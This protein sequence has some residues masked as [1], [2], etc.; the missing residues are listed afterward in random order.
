MFTFRLGGMPVPLSDIIFVQLV[1]P[2][3]FCAN[4]VTAKSA[5][6][7]TFSKFGLLTEYLETLEKS[8]VVLMTFIQSKGNRI[9]KVDI[10]FKLTGYKCIFSKVKLNYSK[11][12]GNTQNFSVNIVFSRIYLQIHRFNLV[13]IAHYLW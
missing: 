4:L 9:P 5:F 8:K 11:I 1:C 10:F 2:M 13:Q 12:L 7:H 6:Y 3:N